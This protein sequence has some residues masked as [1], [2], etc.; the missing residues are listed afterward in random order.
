MQRQLGRSVCV[1]YKRGDLAVGMPFIFNL[2]KGQKTLLI[3]ELSFVS[4]MVSALSNSLH[5]MD[6]EGKSSPTRPAT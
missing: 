1:V 3:A 6:I 5:V 2:G 4:L